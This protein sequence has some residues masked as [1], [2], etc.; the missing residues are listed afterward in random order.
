MSIN[1]LVGMTLLPRVTTLH[2]K[3]FGVPIF[4]NHLLVS[5]FVLLSSLGAARLA[6]T[7]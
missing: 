7:I 2:T 3:V 6:K 4:S 1:S 5:L